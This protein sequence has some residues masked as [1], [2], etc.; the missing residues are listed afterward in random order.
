MSTVLMVVLLGYP[1]LQVWALWQ[2]RGGFRVA[3]WAVLATAGA[4]YLWCV[5]KLFVAPLLAPSTSNFYGL[6]GALGLALGGP[7]VLVLLVVIIVMGR[8]VD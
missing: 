2:C 7:A 5:W 8:L 3:A 6:L 4:G 1:V